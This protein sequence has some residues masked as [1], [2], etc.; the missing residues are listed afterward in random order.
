MNQFKILI[1]F[2]LPLQVLSVVLA[3]A[4]DNEHTRLP[5]GGASQ[6]E[7]EHRVLCHFV[8]GGGAVGTVGVQP[9]PIKTAAR[10]REKLHE[11]QDS[12][13]NSAVAAAAGGRDHCDEVERRGEWPATAGI[14]DPVRVSVVVSSKCLSEQYVVLTPRLCLNCSF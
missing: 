4:A 1:C 10:M 7:M 11:L 6:E 14:L 3:H 12:E 5:S 2:L 8:T 9:A 13:A